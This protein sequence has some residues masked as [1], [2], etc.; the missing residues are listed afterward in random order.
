VST[1]GV[2]EASVRERAVQFTEFTEG[3]HY[4]HRGGDYQIHARVV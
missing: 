1:I 4:E 3:Q 2:V